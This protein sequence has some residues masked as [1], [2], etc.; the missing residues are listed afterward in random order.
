METLGREIGF[1]DEENIIGNGRGEWVFMVRSSNQ[2]ILET[3]EVW[4]EGEERIKYNAYVS[5]LITVNLNTG[6]AGL[7]HIEFELLWNI[8]ATQLMES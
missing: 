3:V 1:L 2:C 4:N 7:G 6:L 5:V 8:Q